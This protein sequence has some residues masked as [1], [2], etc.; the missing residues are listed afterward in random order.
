MQNAKN[1]LLGF[2][3]FLLWCLSEAGMLGSLYCF[4]ILTFSG[5]DKTDFMFS[6]L[7]IAR[8]S[9]SQSDQIKLFPCIST[10]LLSAFASAAAMPR[11]SKGALLPLPGF[12]LLPDYNSLNPLRL[13]CSAP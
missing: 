5:F 1:L 12:L 10:T 9:L 8:R 6:K 4:L 11:A 2:R 7:P 13:L 3:K